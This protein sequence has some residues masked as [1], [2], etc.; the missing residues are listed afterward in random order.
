MHENYDDPLANVVAEKAQ[1]ID[2]LRQPGISKFDQDRG[3]ARHLNLCRQQFA[4]RLVGATLFVLSRAWGKA[5]PGDRELFLERIA[6]PAKNT[7][8]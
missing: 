1:I 6:E 8:T 4:D 3:I 2:S 5:S 7:A